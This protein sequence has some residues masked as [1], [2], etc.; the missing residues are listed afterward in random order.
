MN[1]FVTCGT[2]T[3]SEECVLTELIDYMTGVVYVNTDVVNIPVADQNF[4]FKIQTWSKVR[5]KPKIIR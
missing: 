4:Q 2:N 1:T 5:A 3:T